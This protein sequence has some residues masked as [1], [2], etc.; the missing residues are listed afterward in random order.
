VRIEPYRRI[1]EKAFR[2]LELSKRVT[3]ADAVHDLLLE[4]KEYRYGVIEK[5]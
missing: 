2:H 3:E 5:E 1:F 4:Y